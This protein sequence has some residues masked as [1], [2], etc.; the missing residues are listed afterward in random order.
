MGIVAM[1]LMAIPARMRGTCPLVNRMGETQPDE[2][3]QNFLDF[4]GQCLDQ[5]T[6]QIIAASRKQ[7]FPR[8]LLK[9]ETDDLG[10]RC[11]NSSD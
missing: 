4:T 1:M 5:G 3:R 11:F 2:R 9:R 10:R 8:Y 6:R 7:T